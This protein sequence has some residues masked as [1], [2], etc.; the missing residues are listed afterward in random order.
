MSR[1][2]RLLI[3]GHGRHGKDTV[4]QMISD[5]MGLTFSSSSDFVG[6]RAIWPTWGRE[7]YASFEKMFEAR[8]TPENRVVWGNLI[9]AYN[10]PDKSRTATEMLEEGNDMYIGMRRIAEWEACIEKGLFDHVIWVDASARLEPEAKASNELTA[11]QANL[12]IDNNGPEANLEVAITNLQKKLDEEGFD[13]NYVKYNP[14][15]PASFAEI[16]P[17]PDPDPDTIEVDTQPQ[18]EN[19]LEWTDKPENAIQVLDHGFFEVKEVMG[20]DTSIA[21]SARMSYGRGTKKVNNDE[22]LIN[23]QV[24]NHHTSPLEMGEIKF[25]MRMPIFCMR[26]MV[27]HRTANLNEYSGRYSEMVKLFY[28]PEPEQ[29]C[30]QD[31]VN[32][33]G[34]AEPLEVVDAEIAR[35]VIHAAGEMAFEAYDDLLGLGV[36]RE[37][38]RIVLPLNTYTEVVWKLDVSNLIKFLYLRDDDHAQWEIRVYAK[39]I[40]EAVE[41]FFPLVYAAYMRTRESVSLTQ[42]QISAIIHSDLEGLSK[43]EAAQ[44][45]SLYTRRDLEEAL[46]GEV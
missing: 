31:K 43:G 44:V 7:R 13:V 24:R 10:T 39:L 6:R 29:I 26:Q 17:D 32:K 25:H 2:P 18:L 27:R 37:T 28:V 12:Y 30:K 33:Q 19:R 8:I 9:S 4:A 21:E 38:A 46:T 40:A 36:S 11:K 23:Y 5:K 41:H 45:R 3:I 14:K 20:S 15:G 34:S 22:G 42:D 1:K 35:S 16:F